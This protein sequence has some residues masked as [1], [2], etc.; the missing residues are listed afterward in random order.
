M[1][2]P[3]YFGNNS[4]LKMIGL[5][6]QTIELVNIALRISDYDFSI[7]DGLR[8]TE[9][10]QKV[11]NDNKSE[12]DGIIKKSSHQTGLAIDILPIATDSISGHKL[13]MW[14][15]NNPKVKLVWYEVH[16]AFLRTARLLN[17][18]IELGL[19]YNI[20]GEYDYPHIQ[21]NL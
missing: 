7:I 16:R 19:T 20:N 11:F 17:L 5:A 9:Q 18:N 13:D 12:L 1:G 4:Q 10:Q 8:T 21:I 14:N 2:K 6:P 15:Y 3:F